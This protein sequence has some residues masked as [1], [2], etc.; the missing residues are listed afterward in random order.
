MERISGVVAACLVFLSTLAIVHGG[1]GP[2]PQG[3]VTL[4]GG[5]QR[6]WAAIKANLTQ[7][8]DVMPEE[9]FTFQTT[10]ANKTFG[11]QFG[12]VANF[13]YG[14]CSAASGVPNPSQGKNLEQTA[15]KAE[16][17]KALADSTVFCDEAFAKLTDQGALE[18]VTQGRGQVARG[19]VLSN[20]IAHDNEEYGVITQYLRMKGI[21][22]PSTANAAAARGRGRGGN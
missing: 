16:M 12:H 10:P 2:A 20:L 19:A 3:P 22:P 11:A 21:V 7:A 9:H 18:L 8:L 4:A 13:R 6:A 17:V 14:L 5:L 15:T 1:Q